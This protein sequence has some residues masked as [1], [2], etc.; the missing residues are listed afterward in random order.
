MDYNKCLVKVTC[1]YYENYGF[2]EGEVSWKTKGGTYYQ[3]Y[4]SVD[5]VMYGEDKMV[6]VLKEYFSKLGNDFWKVEYLT[7]E[8]QF[9]ETEDITQEFNTLWDEKMKVG[10]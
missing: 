4:M 6:E 7:H 2:S 10:N 9:F 1:Q 3:L 8:I 5:D